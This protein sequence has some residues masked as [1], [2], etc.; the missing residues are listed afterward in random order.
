MKVNE[1]KDSSLDFAVASLERQPND[2]LTMRNGEV[3]LL[4]TIL[5]VQ[6]QLRCPFS[7]SWELAGKI[8]EREGIAIEKASSDT[9]AAKYGNFT[10]QGYIT[11]GAKLGP[12]PLVAAMR[13]YVE[14]KLGPDFVIEGF[15]L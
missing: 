15:T 13:C 7:S 10:Q 4:R 5:G 1:L 9:W 2:F 3:L 8:I 12:T 11:Q 6:Y 14:A